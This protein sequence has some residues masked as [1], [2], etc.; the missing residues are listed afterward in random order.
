MQRPFARH[1]LDASQLS[2]VARHLAPSRVQ[3]PFR[4]Q[5]SLARQSSDPSATH[6]P[7]C[8][9]HAPCSR[10]GFDFAQSAEDLI[11]T[12]GEEQLFAAPIVT[13]VVPDVAVPVDA[14]VKVKK[15]D[16]RERKT[17]RVRPDAGAQSLPD[18][19]FIDVNKK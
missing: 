3:R 12:L 4:A 9:E 10:H 5:I 13:E 17:V 15:R 18:I 14:G 8:S 19:D 16:R 11:K 1:S 6:E 2:F 7:S